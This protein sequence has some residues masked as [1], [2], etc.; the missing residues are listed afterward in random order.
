M[1]GPCPP[2]RKKGGSSLYTP[3]RGRGP[4]RGGRRMRALLYTHTSAARIEQLLA[5]LHRAGRP[6]ASPRSL[7]NPQPLWRFHE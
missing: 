5:G 4:G 3:A 6:S 1:R 7:S 2:S